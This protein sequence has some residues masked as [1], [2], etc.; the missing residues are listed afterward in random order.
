MSTISGAGGAV[1]QG[2]WSYAGGGIRD[3][4]NHEYSGVY[5]GD[6]NRAESLNAVS[7][8]GAHNRVL[9]HYGSTFGGADNYVPNT[10]IY[11]ATLGG[12]Q[13]SA[14]G[15]YSVASGSW[16]GKAEGDYSE[17]AG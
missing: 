10:G 15:M 7:V 6:D 3:Q 4:S 14:K 13:Q 12:H 8:G 16:D 5:G 1:A 2:D 9:A 11:G 17:V